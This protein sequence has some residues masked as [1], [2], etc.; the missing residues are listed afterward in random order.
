M[1]HI[2]VSILLT[3]IAILFAAN[4]VLADKQDKSLAKTGDM[5]VTGVNKV[6]TLTFSVDGEEVKSMDVLVGTDITY[7]PP[8][9]PVKEGFTFVQ[10]KG[11][12]SIMPAENLTVS[13]VYKKNSYK[14]TIVID[15]ETPIVRTLSYGSVINLPQ[16][17]KE[18]YILVWDM[19]TP[20]TV[21]AKDVTIHGAF[22][23]TNTKGDV[24]GDGRV[25][26]ADANAVVNYALQ[27]TEPQNFNKSKADMDADG[28][29]TK[30]DAKMIMDVYLG[31]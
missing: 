19:G 18:G 13:A 24:N 7:L 26:M 9:P 1:K 14:V 12:E 31:K 3:I 17:Q 23:S 10:W 30:K 28:G 2:Q 16:T 29:I 15:G 21:P 6:F 20:E 22:V 27:G 25:T 11:M 4:P 5:E 8:V